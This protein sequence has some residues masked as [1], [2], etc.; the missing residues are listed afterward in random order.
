MSASSASWYEETRRWHE[1]DQRLRTAFH[2]AAHALVCVRNGVLV[3]DMSVVAQPATA[4]APGT[5]GH[6]THSAPPLPTEADLWLSSWWTEVQLQISLAGYLMDDLLEETATGGRQPSRTRRHPAADHG[7]AVALMRALAPRMPPTAVADHAKD[8][9]R[10]TQ[11][12]LLD[13]PGNLE[14]I[15]RMAFR[16][17]EAGR[18]TTGAVYREFFDGRCSAYSV[19]SPDALCEREPHRYGPH[20]MLVPMPGGR[21][22]ERDYV[23]W[24]GFTPPAVKRRRVGEMTSHWKRVRALTEG[25]PGPHI[26]KNWSVVF[27]ACDELP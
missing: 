15:E 1:T 17:R 22:H 3:H 13:A 19:H 5:L 18:L 16:L 27:D 24:D 14:L 23:E 2:E 26:P 11:A 8:V 21:P 4:F 20:Y 6:V 25:G 9:R 12:L 10:K 7:R